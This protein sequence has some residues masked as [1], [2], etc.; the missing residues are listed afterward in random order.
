[1]RIPFAHL[2]LHGISVAVF[3]AMPQV[4]TDA[5]RAELLADLTTRTRA[6][7]LLVQKSALAYVQGGRLTYYGTPD[8]V[9]YLQRAGVSS[10]THWLDV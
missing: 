9:T 3:D 8:L 4:N 1:M 2:N 6:A 5:H 7:G 10:W